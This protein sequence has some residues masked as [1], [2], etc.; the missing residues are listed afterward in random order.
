MNKRSF[1][2]LLIILTGILF[3]ST[4]SYAAWTQAKRDDLLEV[5]RSEFPED[6]P[7]ADDRSKSAS[8]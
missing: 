7:E 4:S 8:G 1:I 2:V 5:L 6:A 3:I